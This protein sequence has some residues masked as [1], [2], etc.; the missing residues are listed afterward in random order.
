MKP[1]ECWY[2]RLTD[3]HRI[4][5]GGRLERVNLSIDMAPKHWVRSLVRSSHRTS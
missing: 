5:H 4:V 3:P 2:L 1:G